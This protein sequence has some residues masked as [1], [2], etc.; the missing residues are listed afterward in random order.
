MATSDV[1]LAWC[2]DHLCA[3]QHPSVL[4]ILAGACCAV[5]CLVVLNSSLLPALKPRM[6]SLG[7]RPSRIIYATLLNILRAERIDL[8]DQLELLLLALHRYRHAFL[9]RL[10]LYLFSFS[11]F[12]RQPEVEDKFASLSTNIQRKRIVLFASL[13]VQVKSLVCYFCFV[14]ETTFAQEASSDLK[15][16]SLNVYFRF[17]AIN[18]NIASL[19]FEAQLALVNTRL[20][21]RDL[22]ELVAAGKT[23]EV[24]FTIKSIKPCISDVLE[25]EYVAR[26]QAARQRYIQRI[27][28]SDQF[29]QRLPLANLLADRVFF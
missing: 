15:V 23:G 7:V 5:L 6:L 11:F 29:V 20:P 4:D 8:A 24:P 18:E 19:E 14:G 13:L 10:V 25:E 17:Q 9:L 3:H 12:P 28:A 27:L 16:L 26:A 1:V 21:A 22:D 2:V